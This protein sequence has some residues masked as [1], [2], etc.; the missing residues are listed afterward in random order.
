MS[1]GRLIL[2]QPTGWFAAGREVAPALAVLSDGAFKLYIHL[3]LQADRHTAQAVIELTDLARV[4]RRDPALIEADLA[5]LQH[6]QGC[7]RR[8]D[9]VE[10]RD[11]F[12]PYRKRVAAAAGNPQTEFVR[13]AREAF[14]KPAC[15]HSAFAAADEKPALNLYRRGVSLERLRRAIRL[16]CAR[17]YGAMVNGQTRLPIT[18]LAY[19]GSL[20]DEAIQPRSP[21]A[22]GSMSGA[23]WR[24]WKS[25]GYKTATQRRP[26][27][28]ASQSRR[29]R[30]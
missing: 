30:E 12:R 20:I 15:V 9:R 19:L 1:A 11:R 25:A 24:S 2:K 28:P 26:P 21:A 22:T 7:E 6:R 3:C 17:K 13:Q 18:S 14:P 5:E 16:G 23:K 27:A 8:A 4:V 10:I 29:R